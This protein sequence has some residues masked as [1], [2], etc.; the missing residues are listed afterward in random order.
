MSQRWNPWP[1]VQADSPASNEFNGGFQL[2]LMI[3]DLGLAMNCAHSVSASV[4]LGSLAK[5]LMVM[6]AQTDANNLLKDI[7]SIQTL[8]APEVSA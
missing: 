2:G 6:H 4:P 7:S 8:Y 1:G 5:N 3:K